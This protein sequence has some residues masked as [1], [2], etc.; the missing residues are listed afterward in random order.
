M[1]D[2]EMDKARLSALLDGE[3]T[4]SE[5]DAVDPRPFL[6]AAALLLA[7]VTA[8]LL[9]W[10]PWAQP[11]TVEPPKGPTVVVNPEAPSLDPI[12]EPTNNFSVAS[13]GEIQLASVAYNEDEYTVN[14]EHLGDG[15]LWLTPTH[16]Q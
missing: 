12:A 7:L 14:F 10:R 11:P 3:L 1:N 2:C 4:A 15:V 6:A 5:R 8:G 16:P 13:A 9:N